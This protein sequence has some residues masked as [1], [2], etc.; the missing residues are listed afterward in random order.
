MSPSE[1]E[2]NKFA[3]MAGASIEIEGSISEDLK[4]PEDLLNPEEII[5]VRQTWQQ[6]WLKALVIS[7]GVFAVVAVFGGILFNAVNSLNISPEKKQVA[8]SSPKSTLDE[9]D[10]ESQEQDKTAAALTSQK[11]ELKNLNSQPA[12]DNSLSEQKYSSTTQISK[13]RTP[14]KQVS[15][16]APVSKP[17]VPIEPKRTVPLKQLATNDEPPHILPRIERRVVPVTIS[18]PPIKS[19]PVDPMKK[20]LQASNIGFY[21]NSEVESRATG[22]EHKETNLLKSNSIGSPSPTISSNVQNQNT[23][24]QTI[25]KNEKRI[26]VGSTTRGTLETPIAWSSNSQNNNKQNFLIRLTKSLKAS[27]NSEV[28]PVGSY[29]VAKISNNDSSGLVN[30]LATSAIVN[31]QGKAIEKSLPEGSILILSKNA[32]ALKAEPKRG[33]SIGN[34]I[35]STLMSAAISGA[36]KAAEIQN[37]PRSQTS[38]SGYNISSITTD[39]QRNLGAGFVSGSFTEILRNMRAASEQNLQRIKSE[40]KVFVLEP[41]TSVII[42][43][44]KSFST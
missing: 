14:T 22:A 39:Q 29:L 24:T 36:S 10:G 40:E 43:I 23:V 18:A 35:G 7:S 28:F 25:D 16:Q 26:L 32:K 30:L 4:Q 20:W 27:D 38:V 21:G 34:S 17:T 41:G 13:T 42:F 12:D 31:S 8:S 33:S 1:L 15:T 9:K 6:P 5:T 44:N 3:R 19:E 2:N 11:N 37:L